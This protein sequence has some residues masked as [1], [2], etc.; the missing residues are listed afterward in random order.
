MSQIYDPTANA[1]VP[2]N[3][4]LRLEDAHTAYVPMLSSKTGQWFALRLWTGK[5]MKMD[6][7]DAEQR[8]DLMN[9]IV[10]YELTEELCARVEMMR[11]LE[12]QP[13]ITE[14]K[15]SHT[16]RTRTSAFAVAAARGYTPAEVSHAYA[17][18]DRL[19][20]LAEATLGARH[21]A[22]DHAGVT[23]SITV[24]PEDPL[25]E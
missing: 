9:A 15:S 14:A 23:D 8:D 21:L 10:R 24:T 3:S 2:A 25:D 5:T 7:V 19:A 4:V 11:A 22:T 13:T 16:E 20:E 12:E 1:M 6:E 17:T 18:L